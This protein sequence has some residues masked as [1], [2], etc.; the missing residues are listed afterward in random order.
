MDVPSSDW[1]VVMSVQHGRLSITT[2]RDH[3]VAVGLFRPAGGIWISIDH[4]S[5]RS[6]FPQVG[7]L[8]LG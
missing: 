8:Q 7:A 1:T 2:S 3:E 6:M 4:R 5:E